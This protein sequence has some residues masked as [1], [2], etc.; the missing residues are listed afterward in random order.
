MKLNLID[1]S[2]PGACIQFEQSLRDTGFAVLKNPIPDFSKLLDHVYS[3]WNRFFHDYN[4]KVCFHHELFDNHSGYF[5][6]KSE[7][8]KD[9]KI[10][11][12]KEFY[13]AY[14]SHH[15]PSNLSSS[16]WEARTK[17]ADLAE[18]LL[19]WLDLCGDF[20][21]DS[22]SQALSDMIKGSNK[23]LLRVLHY[24]PLQDNEDPQAIRA[25]AHED[26]NLLTLLPA[27]TQSGLQLLTKEGTWYDVP[28]EKGAIIV[29]AG[30]MLK[31]A[32]NGYY[33]STTHRV[34]N[35]LGEEAKQS[36]L[37]MPLFLHPR[38]DVRLSERY[39]ADEY[40]NERLK[41]LGL[42]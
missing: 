36:R 40:L 17:L 15:V 32:T 37:S 2:N 31:E 3:E 6:Y 12:L 16:T 10:K 38:D 21:Q 9:S 28:S 19:L 23:T 33:Q 18:T 5:P 8:A 22:R 1:I 11:D 20:P 29:N 14:E 30:D 4:Y 27:A 41:E 34:V 24:P 35:P 7:N 13:H 42:K 25:A 39:T 26:I